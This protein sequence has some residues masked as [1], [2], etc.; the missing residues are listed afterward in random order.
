MSCRA[1]MRFKSGLVSVLYLQVVVH[2]RGGLVAKLPV[3]SVRYISHGSRIHRVRRLSKSAN[4]HVR[5]TRWVSTLIGILISP[6][7]TGDPLRDFAKLIL[8]FRNHF[9]STIF[10]LLPSQ[11][12]ISW[13]IQ[14]DWNLS[15]CICICV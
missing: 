4:A 13:L 6:G 15:G 11:G 12:Y 14:I 9:N 3:H 5:V 7:S 10:H 1:S 2:S 8:F